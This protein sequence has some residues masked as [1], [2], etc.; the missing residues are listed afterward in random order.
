MMAT[1]NEISNALGNARDVMCGDGVETG[2]KK[3][4]YHIVDLMDTMDARLMHIE[5]YVKK[6][7]AVQASISSLA[8]GKQD[9]LPNEHV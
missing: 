2:G 4:I 9:R 3:A 5:L 6:I 7:D 1:N 8:N